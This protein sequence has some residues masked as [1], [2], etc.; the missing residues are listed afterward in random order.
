MCREWW[1]S[2]LAVLAACGGS[3]TAKVVSTD[4]QYNDTAGDDTPP[5]IDHAPITTSQQ[6]EQPV[7]ITATV[8]DDDAGVATVS[9]FYKRADVVE[10]TEMVLD[11][12]GDAWE[13]A[14]PGTNVTGSG[15]N[16]YLRAED[17][18]GNVATLPAN[19]EAD[20]YYFRVSAD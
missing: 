11:G 4:K 9:V 12:S 14:I 17:N 6:F 8:T 3:E 15:M 5:V 18:V 13:K 7:T 20:A 16:Y 19:G 2:G 10:W 1:L